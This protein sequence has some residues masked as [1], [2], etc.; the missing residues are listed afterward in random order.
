MPLTY[1]DNLSLKLLRGVR[2]SD[3][4]ITVS[5]MD[6]VKLNVLPIGDHIYLNLVQGGISE[7]VKYTHNALQTA[8]G[9]QAVLPVTRDVNSTGAKNFAVPVCARAEW[10]RLQMLEFIRQNS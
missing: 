9:G 8:V 7:V 5:S 1:V 10:T 4:S 2:A 3:V 6:A